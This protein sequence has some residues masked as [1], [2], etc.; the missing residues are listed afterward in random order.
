MDGSLV[1]T[2]EA[3]YERALLGNCC[4]PGADA[5]KLTSSS[6]GCIRSVSRSTLG[7]V[8]LSKDNITFRSQA[9]GWGLRRSQGRPSAVLLPCT[10]PSY[11]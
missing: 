5:Q 7:S 8:L 3:K 2:L 1:N 9:E 10:V 4:L 11:M 6:R